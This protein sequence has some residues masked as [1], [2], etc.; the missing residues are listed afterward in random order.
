MKDFTIREIIEYSEKIEQES[1]LFYTSA[2]NQVIDPE[3]SALCRTLA[4]EEVKHYNRL[5]A[6]LNEAAI[7]REE[8]DAR[9]SLDVDLHARKVNTHEVFADASP[10]RALEI[11]YERETNTRDL[12]RMFL[13]FTDLNETVI[14]VFNQ[15]QAQEDGH[16][17][18]IK[19]LMEKLGQ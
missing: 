6:L 10:A 2:A 3:T 16:A 4:E 11:A 1:Y 15:L 7:P 13:S 8:F 17:A 18:R 12:Y 9:L 14:D 19:L 5:K